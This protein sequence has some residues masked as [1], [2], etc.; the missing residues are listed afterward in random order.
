[1]LICVT[2]LLYTS[3]SMRK[4]QT[5]ECGLNKSIISRLIEIAVVPVA[6]LTNGETFDAMCFFVNFS[7]L[8]NTLAL[9]M[10]YAK[11]KILERAEQN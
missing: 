1:M 9:N 4:V 8:A 2:H 11:F 5:Y 3:L 10:K 7:L 6:I